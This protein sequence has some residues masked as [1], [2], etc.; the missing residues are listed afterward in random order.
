MALLPVNPEYD[1]DARFECALLV[2]DYLVSFNAIKR[3]LFEE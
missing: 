2:A 1:D 3:G